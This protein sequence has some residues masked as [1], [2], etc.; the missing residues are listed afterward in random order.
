MDRHGKVHIRSVDK[1]FKILD[2]LASASE[3]SLGEIA[4]EMNSPKPTIHA[5]LSTM[6]EFRCVEQSDEGKYRL[7]IHLF[8]LGSTRANQWGFMKV[9][10]PYLKKLQEIVDETVQLVVFDEGE[11]L[12]LY[13]RESR[14]SL[15]IVSEVGMRLPAHCT[16]VG[17]V[18]L[19]FLSDEQMEEIVQKRGLKSFTKNTITSLENLRKELLIIR[20]QG[21]G[22][23]NEE[24]MEGLR[25]VAAP[26]VR[27][28][29]TAEA[30]VS[31]S[32]PIV[33][34]RGEKLDYSI[35]NL[36]ESVKEISVAL[37]K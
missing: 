23:D 10:V 18:L 15:R 35:K 25:C 17:K 3:M 37:G 21:Y 22:V 13:K 34:L 11:V 5:L 28:D 4:K 20:S 19:S 6:K 2:L 26:I 1:A 8:E 29:G 7:G 36:L 31:I 24:V 9:S 32:G 33:R 16:A 14:Q 27:P 30:A 12:Y